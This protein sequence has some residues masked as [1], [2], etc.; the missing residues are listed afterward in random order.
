MPQT[1][2]LH[3]KEIF[4]VAARAVMGDKTVSPQANKTPSNQICIKTSLRACHNPLQR[5]KRLR[6]FNAFAFTAIFSRLAKRQFIKELVAHVPNG[7]DHGTLGTGLV[8]LFAQ[9]HHAHMHVGLLGD[10]ISHSKALH[11]LI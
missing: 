9:S 4:K 8:Q 7:F 3:P 6:V 1:L 5:D 2:L 10:A 11:D